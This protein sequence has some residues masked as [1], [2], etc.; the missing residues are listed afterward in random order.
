MK[1]LKRKKGS[2]D[3]SKLIDEQ[4]II[5]DKANQEII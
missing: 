3:Q 4:F 2:K 5:L 1:V